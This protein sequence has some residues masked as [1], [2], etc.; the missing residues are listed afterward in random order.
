MRI[1]QDAN[2]NR[3]TLDL[4]LYSARLLNGWLKEREEIDIFHPSQMVAKLGDIEFV[5]DALSILCADQIRER[6]LSDADFGR[7]FK[8]VS[9]FEA[10]RSFQREY[11]DFFPNPAYQEHLKSAFDAIEKAS[12]REEELIS[13]SIRRAAEEVTEAIDNMEHRLCGPTSVSSPPLPD[14]VLTSN[15]SPGGNSKRSPLRGTGRS[16]KNARR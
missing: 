5:I 4:N 14:S 7:A 6:N 13:R 12:R 8:G 11:Q 15:G 9:A 16:G 1:I 3:W 10:Q 2:G